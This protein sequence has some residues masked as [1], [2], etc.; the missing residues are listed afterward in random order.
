MTSSTLGGIAS[1]GG[2]RNGGDGTP[3]VLLIAR[4]TQP[5][6]CNSHSVGDA[7]EITARHVHDTG[8]S[9]RVHPLSLRHAMMAT[10]SSTTAWVRP[11]RCSPG[12]SGGAAWLSPASTAATK[13]DEYCYLEM[14]KTTTIPL[15]DGGDGPIRHDG[16]AR[17]TDCPEACVQEAR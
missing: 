9:S 6:T 14:T 16:R 15:V 3:R 8:T 7:V 13:T 11:N 4:P 2:F 5:S 1:R 12:V 10:A 17:P